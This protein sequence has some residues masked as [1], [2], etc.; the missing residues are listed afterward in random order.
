MLTAAQD[1][2]QEAN[3]F[4]PSDARLL[5]IGVWVDAVDRIFEASYYY[6]VMFNTLLLW[7]VNVQTPH[8]EALVVRFQPS[9]CEGT[10]FNVGTQ[11]PLSSDAKR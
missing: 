3:Y 7:T 9:C 1:L 4:S 2:S 5:Q 11:L 6:S 8:R 10:S